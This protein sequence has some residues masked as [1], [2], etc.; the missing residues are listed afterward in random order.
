[1]SKRISVI[2]LIIILLGSALFI[3]KGH[4][5][6]NN[7]KLS[8]ATAC[9]NRT[10]SKLSDLITSNGAFKD[11]N[12]SWEIGPKDNTLNASQA[13]PLAYY[14]ACDLKT[15]EVHFDFQLV[16]GQEDKYAGLVFGL[17][18]PGDYYVVRA[19]GSEN[20]VTIAQFRNNSRTVLKTF[21]VQVTTNTWHTLLVKIDATTITI[22]L[23][24]K[25][26]TNN[27]PLEAIQGKVGV[28]TKSD[29]VTQFRNLAIQPAG[30]TTLISTPTP[31]ITPSS[32]EQASDIVDEQGIKN[33]ET[34][35]TQALRDK[36]ASQ[37]QSLL[38]SDA[39]VGTNNGQTGD[40]SNK[41][42]VIN[43][44]NNH[45]GT[46]L[47]YVSRHY[48]SHFGYWEIITTGWSGLTTS[49]VDFRFFRYD[50]QGQR[51]VTEGSWL[52]YAVLY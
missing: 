28:N 45:W 2:L 23:D 18:A 5:S 51:S 21:D 39:I 3:F 20:S 30:A 37:L 34:K 16:G 43:W 1:M 44:L 50:A 42:E 36:N 22:S 52:I 8:K 14:P 47:Q 35:I 7:A 10:I 29:S 11:L 32:S 38:T 49:E 13:F 17:T 6:T 4:V 25:V 46:N 19:S 26:I 31:S 24:N 15:G 27:Y 40:A 9:G 12:T 33:A 41:Q 48:V